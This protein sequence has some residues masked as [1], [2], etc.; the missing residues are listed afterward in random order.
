M[1]R[2]IVRHL[3]TAIKIRAPNTGNIQAYLVAYGPTERSDL[4]A[5]VLAGQRRSPHD[6][7]ARWGG[8][9]MFKK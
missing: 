5:S 7:R 2:I 8:L 1:R 6:L 9:I 4:K 3:P